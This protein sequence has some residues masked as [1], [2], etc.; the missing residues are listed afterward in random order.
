MKTF[1]LV[2]ILVLAFSS[3]DVLVTRGMK[4]I[5]EISTLSPRKLLSLFW[6]VVTNSFI[7]AGAAC[8]LLALTTYLT[9]LSSVDLSLVLPS[10]AISDV[11]VLIPAKYVLRE[12]VTLTRWIGAIFI[13]IGVAL[14]SMS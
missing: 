7:L 8:E 4:I 5:G 3:G 1:A 14:I 2:A 10:T 12:K 13:S 11:L 9:A 6:R